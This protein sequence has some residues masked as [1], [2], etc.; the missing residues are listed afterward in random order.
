MQPLRIWAI[1]TNSFREVIRDRILYF[2]GV[3][4]LILVVAARLLPEIAALTE[5]KIL[6]DVGIGTITLIGVLL[7]AFAGTGT[8]A[9]EIERRT[10][11]IALTKPMSRAEFILGKYL[12]LWA[13]IG[14][15][16]AG[17]G[18]LYL[19][20]MSLLGITY[21][22]GALL[23]ALIYLLIELGLVVA[24][25]I[26]FSIFTGSTLAGVLA[27]GIYLMGQLSRDWVEL[28][29]LSKN[30]TIEAI[31]QGLY[32]VLPDLAR[33]NLR[34]EAVYGTF[35][36]PP[37]LLA[38]AAYGLIYAGTLLAIATLIFSRRQF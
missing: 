38:D 3:F 23:I 34:N 20:L 13:A 18:L 24:I 8:I 17:M 33:L 32:L 21:P 4:A 29:K 15:A 11:A 36:R 31:T 5:D 12:G 28:G 2:V 7:A 14:L 30:A 35:A 6:L 1:A 37:D 19:A 22:L 26:V 10:V 27:L 25:A 16:I 9:R